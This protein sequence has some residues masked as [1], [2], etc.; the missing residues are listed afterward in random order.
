MKYPVTKERL[1]IWQTCRH[2]NKITDYLI[3]LNDIL[4]TQM[5][6][7]VWLLETMSFQTACSSAILPILPLCRKNEHRFCR[8]FLAL[9]QVYLCQKR[10]YRYLCLP[11]HGAENENAK[12]MHRGHDKTLQQDKVVFSSQAPGFFIFTSMFRQYI[13]RQQTLRIPA[14]PDT[15]PVVQL[16]QLPC[17]RQTNA[18]F[19]LI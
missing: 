9:K 3:N 2:P 6:N 4:K 17:K 19:V 16:R 10:V 11:L 13:G 8:S 12:A 18:V 1:Q 5:R 7:I 15:H 14:V